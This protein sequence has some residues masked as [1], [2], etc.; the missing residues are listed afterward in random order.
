MF[1]HIQLIIKKK[2][3]SIIFIRNFFEDFIDL[4]N[5]YDSKVKYIPKIN[6]FNETYFYLFDINSFPKIEINIKF[7]DTFKYSALLI[8]CLIFLSKDEKLYADSKLKMK[9]FLEKFIYI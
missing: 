6:N 7:M 2:K 5:S 3:N 4:F 9:E 8:I 1:R